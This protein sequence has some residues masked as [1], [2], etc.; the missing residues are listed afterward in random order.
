[1][2]RYL[3]FG[4]AMAT[5]SRPR[6]ALAIRRGLAG[7]LLPRIRVHVDLRRTLGAHRAR[8]RVELAGARA[9]LCGVPIPITVVRWL[10][11]LAAAQRC[12]LTINTQA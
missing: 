3:A 4:L 7:V 9:W 5:T 1:M 10:D 11:P 12:R 2:T 8:H 6:L